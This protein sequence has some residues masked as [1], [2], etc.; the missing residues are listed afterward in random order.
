MIS[1]KHRQEG[2]EVL[3]PS[4]PLEERQGGDYRVGSRTQR[5]P[6]DLQCEFC[7]LRMTTARALVPDRTCNQHT[8]RCCGY[9]DRVTDVHHDVKGT[10]AVVST[11]HTMVSELRTD[12]ASLVKSQGG[13]DGKNPSVSVTST[14]VH[15]MSADHPLGS[16]QVSSLT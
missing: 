13:A 9:S 16:N 3:S 5:C 2:N 8:C 12:F 15:R 6:P 4:V 10:H 1:G 7:P 14:C 11:T